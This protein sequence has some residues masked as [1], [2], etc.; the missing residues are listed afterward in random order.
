LSGKHAALPHIKSLDGLRGLAVLAILLFHAGHLSGGWLGVDLFFVLS[1][2]LITSLLLEEYETTAGVSLAKFWG[3]RARRLLPALFAFLIGV[4]LFAG[5]ITPPEELARVRADAIA[6]LFY[7]ANWHSIF[8]GHDYWEIFGSP[9]PLDHTWSL[10][11]EEQFYFLWPPALLLILRRARHNVHLITLV[12]LGLA[13]LSAG[14][15]VLLYDPDLGSARVYYG[16][17]TRMAATLIGAAIASGFRSRVKSWPGQPI[18]LSRLTDVA[19]LIALLVLFWASTGLDGNSPIVYRGG[20]FALDLAA[21]LV[22]VC[23]LVVPTGLVSRGLGWAPLRMLGI[24]SYGAYLWH[25]PLYL[26]LTPDRIGWSG[27][28]LT[29]L[30]I[31]L[32][33]VVATLSYF[34]LES[35]IRRGHFSTKSLITAATASGAAVLACIALLGGGGLMSNEASNAHEKPAPT[36]GYEVDVFLLGDSVA[37]EL[38]AEFLQEAQR[39][40][41]RAYEMTAEGCGSLRSSAMRFLGGQTFSLLPCVEFRKD[42]LTA[43]AEAKPRFVVLLE[44]WSGEGLKK[45]AGSWIH[46]CEDAFDAAFVRDLTDLIENFDAVGT[47]TLLAVMPPPISGDL[48]PNYAHQWGALSDE[49]LGSL[50]EQRMACLN[51]ARREVAHT[52]GAQLIDLESRICPDGE[53]ASELHGFEVR[54]DGMHFSGPSAAWV[55]RWLLDE[56]LDE[57]QRAETRETQ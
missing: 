48:S 22:I 12:T 2:F 41:L 36:S 4:C 46:P 32:T 3:R 43:I 25:W 37:N 5:L 35:P 17:D 53:C 20:L 33:L 26:I 38:R 56:L 14:W 24:V 8:A 49:E 28:Q 29:F 27:W 55:S 19:G 39:R 47:R 15:M 18:E 7:V 51:D 34:A 1:G 6:T 10:A 50:F 30:R 11:I 42:W 9:S 44:G 21:G 45:V 13:L 54:P 31:T 23:V 16:T 40:G 52:T 57:L